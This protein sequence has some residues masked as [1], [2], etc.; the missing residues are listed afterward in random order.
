[1]LPT[2]TDNYSVKN[3]NVVYSKQ[4]LEYSGFEILETLGGLHKVKG[5]Y[6][7]NQLLNIN[8]I[9]S[10][11]PL[12]DPVDRTNLAHGP[13]VFS[14]PRPWITPTV[15][16]D[17][18]T[19]MQR[20]V[21]EICRIGKKINI[22][23]SG[24]IDSTTIVT[25]FLQYAPDLK[26]C[27]IIYSPWSVYEHS[28]FFDL[29]K[30]FDDLE[31]LDI[32]GEFYLD[33]D[34]DGVFVSGNSGD[35]IHASLDES[36]FDQYGYDFLHTPWKDFFY[37]KIPDH[38]FIEFCE[39][40]FSAAGREIESVLDARWWFYT[41][42]K[43][44]SILYNNDF[45][46][47]S[48]GPK[49]FDST[50]LIGFFD[51][52]HYEQFIYFNTDK[53][54]LSNNYATWKQFLKDFCCEHDGFEDWRQNKTKFHSAQVYIYSRKKQL[55]NNQRFLMLFSN[56]QKAITDNLPLFSRRE[57]DRVKQNYQHVFRT[58]DSV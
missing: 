24:G 49:C 37:S 21:D 43:L 17:L 51:C 12:F 2:E 4:L 14:K 57:W 23:W 39:Q 30:T 52:I 20:R 58:P 28:D 27:R 46:F 16:I 31:L 29:I 11:K 41:S 26:Q 48:S 19:A 32:S 44:T 45:V 7:Y 9:F 47:L 6:N 42:T 22:F 40:H 34:L 36:F 15:E 18:K 54:V 10:N 25:A 5:F 38:K 50:R 56:G 33:F 13:V 35:E 53:I 8:N 55:L 3:I 1:M